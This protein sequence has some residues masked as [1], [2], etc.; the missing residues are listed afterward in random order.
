MNYLKISLSIFVVLA[1]SRFIP[2]PPNFTSLLA[3]SFYVP[4]LLGIRYIPIVLFSFILTDIFIGI[5]STIIFTWGTVI[6][7]GLYSKYFKNTIFQ[8]AAG[9]FI[10]AVIFFVISNFGVWLQGDYDYTIV[11]LIEC[12]ILAIPFFHFTL[13][14]TIL[15]S[16]IF[17][18]L[19]YSKKYLNY[20]YNQ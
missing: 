8:R 6:L 14:S 19:I 1:A 2:H 13:L 5:H 20:F 10:G 9:A 11:G 17:E 12:Y 4:A 7:I 16:L 15:Y 3:I 18:V